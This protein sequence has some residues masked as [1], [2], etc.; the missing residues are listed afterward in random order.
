[1]DNRELIKAAKIIREV[2]RKLDH[3]ETLYAQ[4]TQEEMKLLDFINTH[5]SQLAAEVEQ[6][7]AKHRKIR[8]CIRSARID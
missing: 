5:N 6:A 1:M 8:E 3:M 7:D 4:F 2:Q